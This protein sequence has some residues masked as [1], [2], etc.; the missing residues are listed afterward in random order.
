MN[1]IRH[2]LSHMVGGDCEWSS[3]AYLRNADGSFAQTAF[4]LGWG[5]SCLQ[6]VCGIFR[7]AAIG[8]IPFPLQALAVASTEW[9]G[10]ETSSHHGRWTQGCVC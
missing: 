7:M 8:S 10:P 5:F 2:S 1:T 6:R 9:R 4:V 3:L